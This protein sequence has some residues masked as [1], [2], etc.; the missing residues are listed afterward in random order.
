MVKQNIKIE[1]DKREEK[2]EQ[3][4]IGRIAVTEALRAG[5]PVDAVYI[6]R[7]KRGGALNVILA[8]ARENKL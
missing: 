6:A 3:F 1:Q 7:G 2:Q 4:I 8:L 5:R